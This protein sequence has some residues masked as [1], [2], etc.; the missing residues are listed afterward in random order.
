MVTTEGEQSSQQQF[1]VLGSPSGCMFLSETTLLVFKYK[2]VLSKD[3]LI[4]I[5]ILVN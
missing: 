4:L 5:S 2:L 1:E 3:D